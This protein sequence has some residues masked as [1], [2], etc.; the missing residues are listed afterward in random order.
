MLK[1]N[2][3][4]LVLLACG[5]ANAAESVPSLGD[6]GQINGDAVLSRAKANAAQ[7][8]A[9][10]EGKNSSSGVPELKQ[11]IAVESSK[12]NSVNA[13]FSQGGSK[14]EANEGSELPGGYK[15]KAIIA[16]QKRVVLV[17]GKE[18]LSV[19]IK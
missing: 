6:L 5:V 12:G 19:G 13:I 3:F 9:D 11:I 7:A 15:V 1:N 18:T 8:K 4:V 2:L 17:R 14:I 10:A 16:N